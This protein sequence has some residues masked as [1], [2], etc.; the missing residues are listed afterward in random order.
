MMTSLPAE[1]RRAGVS[2]ASGK[3]AAGFLRR[4]SFRL[5]RGEM[6][7]R[8]SFMPGQDMDSRPSIEQVRV[9]FHP[10]SRCVLYP[11]V[12]QVRATVCSTFSRS[13]S[14]IEHQI[15]QKFEAI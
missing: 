2:L 7:A 8:K 15:L 10:L 13:K 3:A 12:K 6:E 11:F 14:R 1:D 4:G 9:A 5:T